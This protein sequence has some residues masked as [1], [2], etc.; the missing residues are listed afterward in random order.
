[1]NFSHIW[2]NKRRIEKRNIFIFFSILWLEP[3][4]TQLKWVVSKSR[5]KCENCHLRIF[6]IEK[7]I[8][9]SNFHLWIFPLDLSNLQVYT[10]FLC[11]FL[12]FHV[13]IENIHWQ[14]LISNLPTFIMFN[15]KFN[16]QEEIQ[17]VRHCRLSCDLICWNFWNLSQTFY[18]ETFYVFSTKQ[19]LSFLANDTTIRCVLVVLHLKNL[20]AHR[21]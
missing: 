18:Y 17:N 19:M 9:L 2:V 8:I 15:E 1:M 6:I 4:D 14:N 5:R 11:R 20:T 13:S 21:K 3:L 7:K 12:I 10:L 16:D